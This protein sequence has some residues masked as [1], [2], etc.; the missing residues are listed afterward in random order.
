MVP[1]V[2]F[3]SGGSGQRG[4]SDHGGHKTW[5]N[6]EWFSLQVAEQVVCGLWYTFL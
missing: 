2:G 5:F 4:D 6:I 1:F 3:H